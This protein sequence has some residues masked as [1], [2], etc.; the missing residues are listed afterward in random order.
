MSLPSFTGL[1]PAETRA[2]I[3][4]I[5]SATLN[6]A[7]VYTGDG[8]ATPLTF[9]TAGISIA[10]DVAATSVTCTTGKITTLAATTINTAT[11]NLSANAAIAGNAMIGGSLAVTGQVTGLGVPVFARMTADVTASTTTAV[12]LPTLSFIPVSGAVYEVEIMLVAQ[13]AATTTGVQIVNTG[14]AG[15]LVLVDPASAFSITAPAG[16][17]APTASPVANANFGILLKGFFAASSTAELTFSVKSEI[18][19]SAVI[20]KADSLRKITR[21]S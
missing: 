12:A 9:T 17:Y 16:T 6:G 4:H 20:I 5:S 14:G 15:T 21:I 2:Y 11:L 13:S 7:P 18:A 10:G 8:R 19:A 3:L 1:S